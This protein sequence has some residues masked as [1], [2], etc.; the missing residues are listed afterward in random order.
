V[1]EISPFGTWRSDI[2]TD[3]ITQGAVS[4][5][6]VDVDGED[7][8]W[9]ELRPWEAGRT[10]LVR[11]NAKGERADVTPAPMNVRSRVHEYG[12]LCFV[13]GNG[14]VWFVNGADNRIYREDGNGTSCPLTRKGDASFADLILDRERERLIAVREDFSGS[15][16]SSNSIVAIGY[17]GTV[18]VLAEG[19]DFYAFPRL[20]PDGVDLAWV[21]W[22]HPNMPW[23]GSELRLAAF[24]S[25]GKLTD[26]VTIAGGIQE[27]VFQPGWSP[28]GELY[29]VSDRSGYWNLYRAGSPERH[30][31]MAAECGMPLWQF[32][33]CTYAFLDD[34]RAALT[35][36]V[37]GE[38]KLGILDLGTG[39]LERVETGYVSIAWMV[40]HDGAVRFV[41]G[42]ADAPDQLI[43]WRPSDDSWTVLRRS[44]DTDLDPGS[45]SK[46]QTIR[47]PTAEG[48]EAYAYFYPPAN[49][50]FRAPQGERPP[51]IV[52]GHGGPTGQSSNALALKIQYWTSRGFAVVDV[53]YGGS[54]GYGRD[55]RQRLD[56]NWG[57]VDVQDCVNAA[58][59]LADQGMVDGDRMAITGGSAGGFTVL[60]ALTFHDVF[61]A[62][63]SAYGIGDLEALTRDTHKFESRYLDRLVGE[64]PEQA[65]LYRRRSPIH[66]TELLSCPVI[67]LQGAEDKVVPPNQAESMVAALKEKGL[68]VAYL[69]FDGE[70]HGFR[71][72]ENVRR[73]LEAELSFYAQVFGFDPADRITPVMI[74]NL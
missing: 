74:E 6:Q 44:S 60:S 1:P 35:Y 43:E 72:A 25:A 5:G 9:T 12:G 73:A 16:E 50:A 14:G 49:A 2:T 68:P 31:A 21:E 71:R 45:I 66:H 3:L 15:G 33:M 22:R 29:Y 19:A 8:Y 59:F 46:A 28:G 56:G 20:S 4:L 41:G 58:R 23:D 55:Y 26:P 42:L 63:C 10:V 61:K 53:N 47:F 62:G 51:L 13:A 70:G 67:F 39:A 30:Y 57:I 69:L 52:K 7:I 11:R 17:D 54:T 37:D 36:A 48:R 65:D 40:A 64:W 34:E 18:T 38:W 27:S 24:D 32:G